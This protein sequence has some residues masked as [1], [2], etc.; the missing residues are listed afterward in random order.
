[1]TNSYT[2]IAYKL[3]RLADVCPLCG[4]EGAEN[5]KYHTSCTNASCKNYDAAFSLLKET[6]SVMPDTTDK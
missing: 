6:K 1:M 5:L 4:T 3:L 2:K